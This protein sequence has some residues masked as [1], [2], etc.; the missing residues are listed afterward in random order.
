ML[1][2]EQMLDDAVRDYIAYLKDARPEVFTPEFTQL[3]LHN[4]LRN[5]YVTSLDAQ[6]IRFGFW[7]I[8]VLEEFYAK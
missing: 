3:W 8:R 4:M 6:A 5:N 2:R 7:Q 1:T